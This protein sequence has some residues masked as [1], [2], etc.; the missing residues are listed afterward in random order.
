MEGLHAFRECFSIN[1]KAPREIKGVEMALYI[2]GDPVPFK[3]PI[4]KL[5]KEEWSTCERDTKTILMQALIERMVHSACLRTE[6]GWDTQ[7]RNR[8][9]RTQRTP[10]RMQLA[11][12]GHIPDMEEII[13][14]LSKATCNATYRSSKMAGG[15]LESTTEALLKKKANA[16]SLW[17][18]RWAAE[19]AHARDSW[20]VVGQHPDRKGQLS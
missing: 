8:L 19:L 10:R 5:S 9:Q 2:K 3:R 13:S 17:I 7:V 6:E 11:S 14:S 4:L 18:N 16:E 1:P 20:D 15:M 12:P